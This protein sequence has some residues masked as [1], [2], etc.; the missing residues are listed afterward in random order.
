TAAATQITDAEIDLII[1]LFH[2]AES[3]PSIPGTPRG[4]PIFAHLTDPNPENLRLVLRT[5]LFPNW[6]MQAVLA[7][8][9]EQ[10]GRAR[11]SWTDSGAWRNM[12][13][14]RYRIDGPTP[15]TK[16]GIAVLFQ[17]RA[18]ADVSAGEMAKR[19]GV[20]GEIAFRLWRYE[21]YD[22]VFPGNIM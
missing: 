21:G 9:A 11:D 16:S 3:Q 5:G 10:A 20:R 17:P 15:R 1:R 18:V 12:A 19:L 7:S 22:A 13:L 6:P 4:R 14:E 2:W 8:R